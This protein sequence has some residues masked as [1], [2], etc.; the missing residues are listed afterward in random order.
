MGRLLNMGLSTEQVAAALG[1]AI[2][3]V[4][5]AASRMKETGG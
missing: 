2:A 1:L 3:E 5:E 4:Q